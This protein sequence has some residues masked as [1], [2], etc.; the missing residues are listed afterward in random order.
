MFPEKLDINGFTNWKPKKKWYDT[1]H[2][3]NIKGPAV[4]ELPLSEKLK[5]VTLDCAVKKGN[6]TQHIIH[7]PMPIKSVDGL[8]NL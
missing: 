2:I 7:K 1:F 8:A 3:V 5:L 4:L 6:K